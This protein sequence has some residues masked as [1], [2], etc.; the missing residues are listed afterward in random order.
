MGKLVDTHKSELR[1]LRLEAARASY[2]APERKIPRDGVGLSCNWLLF[3][4]LLFFILSYYLARNELLF[5]YPPLFWI[6]VFIETK[7]KPVWWRKLQAW[8]SYY[9][10]KK[11]AIFKRAKNRRKRVKNTVISL[12]LALMIILFLAAARIVVPLFLKTMMVVT[13]LGLVKSVNTDISNGYFI[14]VV[15]MTGFNILSVIGNALAVFFYAVS[16][17]LSARNPLTFVAKPPLEALRDIATDLIII[18][19]KNA[20]L[21]AVFLL[22]THAPYSAVPPD[23][24]SISIGI[25]ISFFAMLGV[26]LLSLKYPIIWGTI[27]R[28][29]TIR[30][31]K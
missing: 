31:S 1:R 9:V 21:F 6:T 5:L 24:G 10:L 25:G 3:L 14:T 7:L 29:A 19:I 26:A 4:I 20:L 18:L 2:N 28:R 15:L 8:L 13:D 27:F 23:D 30:P 17:R 16:R 12:S 11:L 22:L